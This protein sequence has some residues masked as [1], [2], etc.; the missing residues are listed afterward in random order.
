METQENSYCRLC[1][2][3]TPSSKLFDLL[4]DSDRSREVVEKLAR[5]K[6]EFIN[7]F[8]D[9]VLPKTVCFLCLDSLY[10]AVAFV[11]KVEGAQATLRGIF[12]V[13][14]IKVEIE[15]ST[16]VSDQNDDDSNSNSNSNYD[17]DNVKK[18]KKSPVKP[19]T[20]VGCTG[21]CSHQRTRRVYRKRSRN[22]DSDDE[23]CLSW[24]D[25]T[26][27]CAFCLTEFPNSEELK[28][29]SMD[30]HDSCTAFKCTDCKIRKL[31]LEPFLAHVMRHR[32]YLRKFCYL[33]NFRFTRRKEAERHRRNHIK[34]KYV[35]IG[36]QMS[37]KYVKE[38]NEHKSKYYTDKRA[39]RVNRPQSESDLTC[40]VCQKKFKSRAI[41]QAHLLIHTERRR[42]HTCDVCGKC[43]YNKDTLMSHMVVHNE[44]RPHQCEICKFA[45]KTIGQLRLHV[46]THDG[47]RPF[48]CDQCGK[49]FRLRKNLT[50]HMLTHTDILP[51]ECEY[52]HKRFRFKTILIQHIRQH[53]GVKPYSCT[54]CQRAF[55][56][57]SNYNKHMKR[58][59]GM[60][61]AKKKH[62][63]AGAFPINPVTGQVIVQPP[64]LGT[65]EWKKRVLT[66]KLV[67]K[68]TE[69]TNTNATV[70]MNTVDSASTISSMN[71]NTSTS[72]ASVSG[73]P[74]SIQDE[75]SLDVD[76]VI[77]EQFS[78]HQAMNL[79]H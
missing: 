15:E 58:R 49:R 69:P 43:F 13:K 3:P 36:C 23:N 66:R 79:S 27:M 76:L 65:E 25:Y 68:N 17:S 67:R 60:E 37:F 31:K 19:E 26:W 48:A 61:M 21:H 35:C 32:K 1:A 54:L 72:Y 59:H 38:L 10:R 53:T 44:S 42:D 2:E 41:L 16:Q 39:V 40:N 50:S 45:F 20:S 34:N 28:S 51:H 52:C 55:T 57:W 77:N 4:S 7:M 12:M 30:A 71:M 29:H 70:G 8:R 56:N 63:P 73:T 14:N 47:E 33:C 9:N 75:S 6:H 62:T 24:T 18:E 78:G 46:G 64:S 74:M 22:D 11:E 5:L